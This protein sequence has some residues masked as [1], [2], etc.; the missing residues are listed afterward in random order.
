MPVITKRYLSDQILIKLASGLVESGFQVDERDVY[1]RIEQKVNA[2]YKMQ[3]FSINLPSGETI[4][5]N[6]AIG[7]Y[8]DIAVVSSGYKSYAIL[9][10]MPIGLPRNAGIYQVYDPNY[11]ENAFIPIMRGQSQLLKTDSLLS[12]MMGQISYEPAGKKIN[13]SK[14]LTL[15]GTPVVT[16]ELVCMDMS[17]YSDT[18]ML[19]IPAS[20]VDAII[21]DI[22]KE[23]V[24]VQPGVGL[25]NNFSN[26]GQKANS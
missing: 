14:D 16:M 1:A 9:P 26:D 22:Y 17:L 7:I 3:Q 4:P 20:D 11:P 21:M 24:P 19:P 5:E 8:E 23:Y 6:L 12:D 13:F 25:V 15:M 18:D 2:A 10:V